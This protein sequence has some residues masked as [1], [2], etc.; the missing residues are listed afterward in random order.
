[1]ALNTFKYPDATAP[2]TTLTFNNAHLLQDAPEIEFNQITGRAKGGARYTESFGAGFEI[3]PLTIIVPMT[4]VSTEADYADLRTFILTTVNGAENTFVWTD[5]NSV[6]R[7]V[8]ITNSNVR[9]ETF[10]GTRKS[11][12]LNLEV[13][14]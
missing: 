6:A 12:T 10:G 4:K 3:F 2:T 14:K 8:R 9:F 5:E 1:M 13:A 11:V 7:T